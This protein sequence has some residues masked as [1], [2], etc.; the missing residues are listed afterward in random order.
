M[1]H[2][3]DRES[4]N[5]SYIKEEFKTII[6][7]FG[8]ASQMGYNPNNPLKLNQDSFVTTDVKR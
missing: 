4:L 1:R 6:T 8:V 7:K 3:I 5:N 2:N